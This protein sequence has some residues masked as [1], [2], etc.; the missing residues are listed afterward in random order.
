MGSIEALRQKLGVADAHVVREG[1]LATVNFFDTFVHDDPMNWWQYL[2]GID[3]HQQVEIRYL[4][5]GTPLVRYESPG[6][7]LLKPFSYFTNP[8]SSPFRGRARFPAWECKT[9]TVL[10]EIPTLVSRSS[11]GG[12]DSRSRTA[13]SI[14]GTQFLIAFADWPKLIQIDEPE[15]SADEEPRQPRAIGF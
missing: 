6:E 12:F 13:R 8:G 15:R 5:R 3:F 7:H 1:L 11:G 10:V 4:G 9:F 2:K 14:G